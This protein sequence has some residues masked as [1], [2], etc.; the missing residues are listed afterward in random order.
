[1]FGILLWHKYSAIV[2]R[3]DGFSWNEEMFGEFLADDFAVSCKEL[4]L[5]IL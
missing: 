1:M 3:L 2:N 4:N 5:T